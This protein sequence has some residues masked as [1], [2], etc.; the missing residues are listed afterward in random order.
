M[1]KAYCYLYACP[2]LF[3]LAFFTSCN[4]QNQAHFPKA[5]SSEPEAIPFEASKTKENKSVIKNYRIGDGVRCGCLDKAGIL[6][7][8]TNNE[9]VYRYDGRSFTNFSEQDGLCSN[10]VTAIIE[11]DAGK[12]WFGTP[13]GLCSYDRKTFKHVPIPWSDTSSTWLDKVYPVVNPNEV[14]CMLQDKNGNFWIGTNGAGAYRFDGKTFTSFLSDRGMKYEDGLP[15]NIIS[16]VIEDVAGNIWFTSRSHAGLSRFDGET[17]THFAP[18]DGLSDDM[19]N[20]SFQ[21]SVGN[22]WFGSLGNRAGCLDRYDPSAPLTPGGKPFTH[23]NE[24][25]GL[26]NNNI[27][28]IYE[29]KTGNFWLGSARG[30]LCIYDPSASRRPGGKTFTEFTNKEGQRFDYILFIVEDAVGN[31]WFGGSY[32]KLFR[33]DGKS[34]TDFT[35]KGR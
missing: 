25:D 30:N 1:K 10:H 32:G 24:T 23:F 3:M 15:H 9:G 4:G 12:L 16:S 13:D 11:D 18:K 22:I 17:F 31:I 5:G 26:C 29:D 28:C 20:T 8:G 6:W 27:R 33:Y 7:F 34:I 19:Y 35:Q 2:A 21:D 14:G